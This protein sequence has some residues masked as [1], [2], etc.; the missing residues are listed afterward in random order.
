[1]VLVS[2]S[3]AGLGTAIVEKLSRLHSTSI[4]IIEIG[5]NLSGP[6]NALAD[7]VISS[8]KYLDENSA[9]IVIFT[10]GT[11]GKPKG[12]VLRR[13]YIHEA[14]RG[15]IDHFD[16]RPEDVIL[17]VLP[18]HHVTGLVINFLP[19]IMAGA[20]IE[21]KSGGFDP[22]WTWDRWREGGL[23]FFS[24]VPTIFLRMMRFHQKTIV[25]LPMA[26][27][28]AYDN[29]ASQFRAM[30]CGTSALP[31]PMQEFWTRVRK[32]KTI[33]TRYG[34]TEVGAVLKVPLDGSVPDGSVGG[35]VAGVELKLSE[36][37][38]GEILVKSPH[39]FAR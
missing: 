22:Q 5:P 12:A 24:G 25:K 4:Q 17:H 3:A 38:E 10:S 31:R 28:T 6:L 13:G 19:F 36:G 1:M 16:L 26:D 23:T 29:A 30:I 39:L 20:C 33:L 32:G 11:T 37:D 14:A 15:V 21:F 34:S 35:I 2:S 18:V 8:D 7:I 9:G 27:R